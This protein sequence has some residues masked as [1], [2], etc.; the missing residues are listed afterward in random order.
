MPQPP[1]PVPVKGGD[2]MVYKDKIKTMI[3]I[4]GLVLGI[5]I[6]GLIAAVVTVGVLYFPDKKL[7]TNALWFLVAVCTWSFTVFFGDNSSVND[8]Y[9]KN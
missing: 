6:I 7:V 9:K 2:K 3:K 4:V 5:S 8:T 1:A